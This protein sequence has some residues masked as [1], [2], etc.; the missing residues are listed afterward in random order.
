MYDDSIN[1]I[2]LEIVLRNGKTITTPKYSLILDVEDPIIDIESPTYNGAYMDNKIFL[3]GT[4]E[5]DNLEQIYYRVNQGN[6][7]ELPYEADLNE[8]GV[9]NFE[10][11]IAFDTN[12][13]PVVNLIEVMVADK[14][15]NTVFEGHNI[16]LLSG[17][18]FSITDGKYVV[19]DGR[20]KS[21]NFNMLVE[22][23]SPTP[24]FNS[25]TGEWNF[26]SGN[27]FHL[28]F[29]TRVTD[30]ESPQGSTGAGVVCRDDD[31]RSVFVIFVSANDLGITVA[32]GN[33]TNIAFGLT[34]SLTSSRNNSRA[35]NVM[36]Y[37]KSSDP[38]T[39]KIKS[40][41]I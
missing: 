37:L 25:S 35:I 21:P 8:D 12:N 20:D 23:N 33:N 4:I 34:A 16:Q 32:N 7:I 6:Y 30:L 22:N 38:N 13:S 39:F 36:N 15:G 17:D 18:D 24:F 10:H 3:S 27:Q 5:E 29:N 19:K 28:G 14:A 26:I 9:Y 31:R 11:L 2:H 1:N 40:I 41:A